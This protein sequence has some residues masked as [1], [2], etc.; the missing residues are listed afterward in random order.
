MIFKV[1]GNATPANVG[2]LWTSLNVHSENVI[3]VLDTTASHHGHYKNRIVLENNWEV[4]HPNEVR[5]CS[6]EE[7]NNTTIQS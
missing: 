6:P 7:V 3:A 1:V 4:F 2:G 5:K